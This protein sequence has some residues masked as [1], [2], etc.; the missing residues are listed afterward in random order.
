SH[1]AANTATSNVISTYEGTAEGT[2]VTQTITYDAWGTPSVSGNED[3]R[4][5]WK[6]LLWEGDVVGLYYMRGRWYDPSL[7]RF[8]Q[9]DP[10][11][12]GVND[13]TFA[14]DDPVNGSD[15]SGLLVDACETYY[16]VSYNRETGQIDAILGS[17]QVC[18]EAGGGGGG[19]GGSTPA[20]AK[21]AQPKPTQPAQPV[22]QGP[23]P[24]CSS[25]RFPGNTGQY[26]YKQT[27]RV[28]TFS[29]ASTCII[30]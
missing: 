15:P 19:G 26:L 21:P 22:Q 27:R 29:G 25:V 20:Q 24:L 3:S 13:Y 1:P 18:P 10:I 12:S 9:E 28:G 6:G 2:S 5:M 11:H 17:F 16:I 7:G 4:L 30:P 23:L 14:G 8:I